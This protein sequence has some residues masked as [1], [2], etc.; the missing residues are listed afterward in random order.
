MPKTQ[1]KIKVLRGTRAN[2][3][4]VAASGKA[5]NFNLEQGELALDVTD[6]YLIAGK[7]SNKLNNGI[8]KTANIV[9][10]NELVGYDS[11]A[12]GISGTASG[13]YSVKYNSA[14]A[15]KELT[16][17]NENGDVDTTAAKGVNVTAQ[18]GDVVTD[19]TGGDIKFTNKTNGKKFIVNTYTTIDKDGKQLKVGDVTVD[20]N[21]NSYIDVK[22]I[23]N[24][25]GSDAVDINLQTNV[26]DIQGQKDGNKLVTKINDDSDS[27]IDGIELE[28]DTNT[29]G[30]G[31]KKSTIRTDK[32]EV[33]QISNRAT[34][35]G[36]SITGGGDTAIT[37]TNGDLSLN[38]KTSG[39]F[40]KLNDNTTVSADGKTLRVDNG[41]S[42]N[43]NHNT[44]ITPT[45]TN[46][47][48]INVDT[49]TNRTN[50]GEV[51]ITNT[52]LKN[53]S[54]IDG[55]SEQGYWSLHCLN[56]DIHVYDPNKTYKVGEMCFESTNYYVATEETTGDPRD[57]TKWVQATIYNS[58]NEP[59]NNE[60]YVM[61]GGMNAA[62]G[63][64][65]KDCYK[66]VGSISGSETPIVNIEKNFSPDEQINL[67]GGVVHASGFQG[68]L[69]VGSNVAPEI[70]SGKF[71]MFRQAILDMV[72]PVGSIYM[73]MSTA[74]D[75][76]DP[77]NFLGGT[78]TRL[79]SGRVLMAT[80]NNPEQTGGNNSQS[81]TISNTNIVKS[82]LSTDGSDGKARLTL[83]G[84]FSANEDYTKIFVT[85]DGVTFTQATSAIRG[86]Y[87]TYYELSEYYDTTTDTTVQTGKKYYT[88]DGNNYVEVTPE[89]GDNPS[90]KG[91]FEKK[92]TYI[93]TSDYKKQDGKTYYVQDEAG[94]EFYAATGDKTPRADVMYFKTSTLEGWADF[95]KG[96]DY[97]TIRGVNGIFTHTGGTKQDPKFNDTTA[98]GERTNDRLNIN[99][100]HNHGFE[101]G[102]D[103]PTPITISTIQPYITCYMWKRIA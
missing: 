47:D 61:Y 31:A 62:E 35:G 21:T 80:D 70:P 81:F 71:S 103:N 52:H 23:Q 26:G 22:K 2:I 36:I 15:N 12:S 8:N 69:D 93:L 79:S 53:V 51:E 87:I 16:V 11:D 66:Y 5:S 72:Y 27:G 20:G 44:Q 100:N 56:D 7:D 97:N 75:K 67:V 92:S 101:I 86:H 74:S 85:S 18:D 1:E 68:A 41:E 55:K 17:K 9:K 4:A 90:E 33:D 89:E 42:G 76:G 102:V 28:T 82:K 29:S 96:H 25:N 38:A 84:K 73:S 13:E 94:G 39:K 24:N 63:Q 34:N 59:Y 98:H 43:D 64:D 77:G 46:T 95:M 50:N 91:W 78:W 37:S 3:A 48:S 19:A 58:S 45:N 88:Y 65:K 60:S 6:G 99:A 57:T 49:I 32:L 14:S 83:P 30:T 10:T 54:Y 40:I